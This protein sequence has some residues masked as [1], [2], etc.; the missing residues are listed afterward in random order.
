MA[1]PPPPKIISYASMAQ[2][3]SSVTTANPVSTLAETTPTPDIAALSTTPSATASTPS[4]VAANKQSS[5]QSQ[6]KHNTKGNYSNNSNYTNNRGRGGTYI[7][8]NNRGARNN[9][10]NSN[11]YSNASN[12][13]SSSNNNSNNNAN[14]QS[15]DHYTAN[16]Q[17]NLLT[18][19]QTAKS[20]AAVQLEPPTSNVDAILPP[21]SAPL[22]PLTF[23]AKAAQ[24]AGKTNVDSKSATK[25]PFVASESVT[26]KPNVP[27]PVSVTKVKFGS[28]DEANVEP[29]PLLTTN[30]LKVTAVIPLTQSEVIP[31]KVES[32]P[33]LAD[34]HQLMTAPAPV[35]PTVAAKQLSHVNELA[36]IVDNSP[37]VAVPVVLSAPSHAQQ[38]QK[39]QS[40]PQFHQQS[41]IHYQQSIHPPYQ[42]G[43]I[44]MTAPPHMQQ[45]MYPLQQSQQFN[46]YSQAAYSQR[47][48]PNVGRPPAAANSPYQKGGL[49]N[50]QYQ[51]I[52]ITQGGPI[53]SPQPQAAITA[54][55]P[56]Y[57]PYPGHYTFDQQPAYYY[58]QSYP[59]FVRPPGAIPTQ[60]PPPQQQQQPSSQS[61]QQQQQQQ[62]QQ[63]NRYSQPPSPSAVP[64][65]FTI[66]LP[67]APVV[68]A[69]PQKKGIRIT[70]PLTKEEIKL[71][72]T[73]VS[74]NA[75]AVS[76]TLAAGSLATIV[77]SKSPNP[78]A[79]IPTIAAPA[80]SPTLVAIPI[81]AVAAPTPIK[82]K[83]SVVLKDPHG[84][85]ISFKKS[86]NAPDGVETV[87]EAL[88]EPVP[89]SAPL[90]PVEKSK[91]QESSMKR[92]K[93]SKR[94]VSPK[95]DISP[96]CGV[97][98]QRDAS[99]AQLV[100]NIEFV[101]IVEKRET[102]VKREKSKS[103]ARSAASTVSVEPA[104][105]KSPRTQSPVKEKL[106]SRSNSPAHVRTP[107]PIVTEKVIESPAASP[108][109]NTQL[110]EEGE[111][112]ESPTIARSNHDSRSSPELP[113]GLSPLG[114]D[115]TKHE[116]DV[117]I[118]TNFDGQ[119][120]PE[121]LTLPKVVGDRIIY[122]LDFLKA[123]SICNIPPAGLPSMDIFLEETGGGGGARAG[124]GSSR[125]NSF[126]G[127]PKRGGS[128]S[129][130][131]GKGGIMPTVAA[132]AGTGRMSSR[133]SL[134]GGDHRDQQQRISS[135]EGGDRGNRGRGGRGGGSGPNRIISYSQF[136]N[137]PYVEPIK[138]TENGWT[139][140]TL[141][142][143]KVVYQ[144]EEAATEAR[145]AEIEKKVKGYLNKL[146]IE[147]FD[148]VS[149]HFLDLPITAPN[150]LKKII[151]LI[152][153][154]A[155]DEQFFQNMYGRLCL[156]LS[157]E[158]PKVQ[159]W[160]DMDTKNNVF[161]RLLLNKCQEEFENSAKWSKADSEEEESRQER[162][163]RLH[164]MSSEE[165]EKYAQD[166]YN[167]SK[168]KRRV[169]GNVTFIGEL[170]NL[171]MITEKI[172]HRCVQQLLR[173]VANPEE[174][175]SECVCKLMK[176][177]GEKL[178]H[179]KGRSFVD[180]YFERITALSN[181]T[182]LTSRIR[183]ML[184][185]LIDL[186]S[187]KWK[188][189]QDEAGPLTIA[190]VH[191]LAE[192][193]TRDE[194]E[195]R[196]RLNANNRG[197]DRRGGDRRDD[198]R[199]NDRRGGGG[200][201]RDRQ[202]RQDRQFSGRGVGSNQDSRI[203]AQKSSDG[204]STVQEKGNKASRNSMS[205]EIS[206]LGRADVKKPASQ[207]Y[208]GPRGG[209]K[210]EE[211]KQQV[212][213]FS[214]LT[215]D[216][217]DAIDVNVPAV[218]SPEIPTLN[219]EQAASKYSGFV[220]EWFSIYD[221]N[222]VIAG[223]KELGTNEYNVAFLTHLINETLNRKAET[224]Q[225]T[226]VLIPA[227]VEARSV[228]MEDV[229][230]AFTTIAELLDDIS[231]DVP[232]AYKFFGV[233]YGS[234][235]A[236]NDEQFT[237]ASLQTFLNDSIETS[238]RKPPIPG[239]VAEALN[240][241]RTLKG[242]DGLI[243]IFS[244]QTVELLAFW[245]A[246]KRT[247][248]NLAEWKENNNLTCLD[249]SVADL[250]FGEL[251]SKVV[252]ED[253]SAVAE[254]IEIK[255]N[256]ET[257]TSKKFVREF[258]LAVLGLLGSKTIFINGTTAPVKNSRELFQEQE[259]F[260]DSFKD[261]FAKILDE[262]GDNQL[263]LELE[264]VNTA[265]EYWVINGSVASFF[266]HL[267]R[268]FTTHGII[269]VGIGEI[270]RKTVNRSND[271]SKK[272]ALGDIEKYLESL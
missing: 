99:P 48:S 223:H 103:P 187:N 121:G 173:D 120:Y 111:I 94:Q 6:N 54:F 53:M 22:V 157:T 158:L 142:S 93:S 96:N 170:F 3:H 129:Y 13:N 242:E 211:P 153:D 17:P 162:L 133:S 37:P 91:S 113:P 106:V 151:D 77:V 220:E 221:V 217:S 85:V 43:A 258:T 127:A 9:Y 88:P 81:V 24:A 80:F 108:Q 200:A 58:P 238:M 61:Q 1:N 51:Q 107:E 219:E 272:L 38:Q 240:T 20:Q 156:K 104:T 21:S 185:D 73:E 141:T 115:Q 101:P 109:S 66:P 60:Q 180:V 188:G 194:D 31:T 183:F 130:P 44:I 36:L 248:Q 69:S 25:L 252:S 41:H 261:V 140:H 145:E 225:K 7:N 204:W 64:S 82:E 253:V 231:V 50:P 182:V 184:K 190:E 8:G 119:V 62:Q 40:Q 167:R 165:K 262:S 234:L 160:I 100:K 26:F 63:N 159:P 215:G 193:K 33:L 208:L 189:R 124:R 228:S 143:K 23:A 169:L 144:S 18:S 102:L 71:P 32:T 232:G 4:S 186:R 264:I 239:I 14:D 11:N 263:I 125:Q 155:L 97:S 196:Q 246:T 197:G 68:L 229:Y 213:Q 49:K 191:A 166:E 161:R 254:W 227:L 132:P 257:R 216:S 2:K 154:K 98:P 214:L 126:A 237:L 19:T 244:R 118:L 247:V 181:N 192:K 171:N 10:A 110:L 149:G 131:T 256:Q 150:I 205:E 116:N 86:T 122:Q 34:I 30:T 27:A 67:Q 255:Y 267:F 148:S 236:S 35:S 224:V 245:P 84:H 177:I 15:N 79:T 250:E 233:L 176:T 251:H 266:E 260:I 87:I 137:E 206:I 212:N 117:I 222:E 12:N 164:S 174:E 271:E 128:G 243:E 16:V 249:V 29:E 65:L 178:D 135:R 39:Q 265:A 235:I 45:P 230:A 105:G 90:I 46:P 83:P 92:N 179:E 226:S 56:Q 163:K 123:F 136:A 95:R 241:V 72:S 268:I 89:V 55:Y 76:G 78:V 70:N 218:I 75:P 139:P 195:A 47:G 57:V 152:F 175:E 74:A 42:Q 199:D 270:W 269:D 201:G 168:L 147:K 259:S 207:V 134:L 202:D 5:H 114:F 59:Q 209:Q 138:T 198:R 52:P 112:V 210:K 28:T 172:M 146:T 203:S